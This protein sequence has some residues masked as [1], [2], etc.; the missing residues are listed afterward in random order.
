MRVVISGGKTLLAR[1]VARVLAEKAQI[2][3]VDN[4][5]PELSVPG[6]ETRAGDLR[7]R[8]FVAEAVAGAEAV[9]HLGAIEPAFEDGSEAIDFATRG[10]Y[11]LATEAAS[12]GV[13]R[14]VVGSSLTLFQ[15]LPAHWEVTEIWRPRPEPRVEHL[16]PYLAELSVRECFRVGATRPL[17]LRFARIVEGSTCPGPDSVHLDDAVS[18]VVSALSVDLSERP[19]HSGW[20]AHITAAG[21]LAKVRVGNPPFPYEPTHRATGS[22][23]MAEHSETGDWRRILGVQQ[24]APSRPIRNV[25][26]FGAGGPVAAAAA[27]ELAPTYTL[28]LTDLRP[29]DAI[30]QENQPQSPGAPLPPLLEAP[31]EGRVVDVCD[32]DAVMAACEGMDAVI[33]CT[34]V[35]TDPVQAFRVNVL[36]TYHILR[37][38]VAH[39]IRRVVQTGPAQNLLQDEDGYC[40]DYDVPEALARPGRSLYFH[41]KYLGQEICR[42]FAEYYGMEVPVLQYCQFF[43]PEME[44]YLHHFG[45]SWQDSARA[46]RRALE[47]PSLPAPCEVLNITAD[48]PHGRYSNRRA[49][50]VLG[51]EPR[52]SMERLWQRS[53]HTSGD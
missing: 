10:T 34:V 49:R 2:I 48:L 32:A 5:L 27:R 45:V 18:G 11:V 4:T 25:V 35:R 37:A 30:V 36:G 43:H 8:G 1:A 21:E 3:L 24:P 46:L 53:G 20:I 38:A 28:R 22:A 52:D 41:T 39:G 47:V 14:F 51:W 15:R 40:W 16:S 6:V 9:V 7:D 23:G 12:A 29:L 31:H 33:N 26:I 44:R 42:V 50:E 13:K 19:R 17:C